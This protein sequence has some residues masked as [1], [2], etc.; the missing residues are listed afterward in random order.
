MKTALL[1]STLNEI[2]GMKA[3]MSRIKK[4]WV[5][6]IIIVDGSSTD[7]T[8]EYARENGYYTFLQEGKDLMSGYRTA[9]KFATGD[10]I[11]TF[12]PDRNSVP[13]LIPV[14]IEKMK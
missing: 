9:M 11:V 2:A 7:G 10:I 5:D 6:Q 3:I 8:F 12:T 13:E 4:E 1:I 14:L